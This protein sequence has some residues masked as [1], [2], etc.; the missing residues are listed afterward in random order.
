MFKIYVIVLLLVASL[1]AQINPYIT[2]Y[3]IDIFRINDEYAVP[4]QTI[5]NEG[6]ILSFNFIHDPEATEP[7]RFKY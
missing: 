6:D 4:N 7:G 1:I 3:E 2:R 5:V